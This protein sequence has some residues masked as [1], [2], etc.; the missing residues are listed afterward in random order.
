M[1]QNLYLAYGSNINTT[2]MAFR[3]PH[4]RVVGT[5]VLKGYRLSFRGVADITPHVSDKVPCLL[6]DLADEDIPALDRYEGFPVLYVK[7]TVSVE[8]PGVGPAFAM[9]Y[10]MRKQQIVCP[11]HASYFETILEGY[12]EAGLSIDA[13]YA[14][15]DRA[16]RAFGRYG[17]ANGKSAN[18]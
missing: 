12:L 5:S 8:V 7:R 17:D 14:A 16:A 18:Y 11:P 4:S 2:Q 6:W 15:R 3:C 1:L 10:V 9:T 13:L